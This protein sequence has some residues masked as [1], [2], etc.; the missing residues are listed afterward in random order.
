MERDRC[1]AQVRDRQRLEASGRSARVKN[2]RAVNSLPVRD[3]E[4]SL[5]STRVRRHKSLLGS[6][7]LYGSLGDLRR[8]I[9]LVH[10]ARDGTRQGLIAAF[11]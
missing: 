3:V 2:F 11:G 7:G 8:A 4:A 5:L 10:I 1:N 9:H 6:S